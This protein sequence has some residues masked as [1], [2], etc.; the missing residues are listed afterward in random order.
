MK[1]SVKKKLTLH[2][3]TILDLAR[4]VG[5]K[6]EATMPISACVPTACLGT[7]CMPNTT[8]ERGCMPSVEVPCDPISTYC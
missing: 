5:G 6:D 3:E 1:R 2:R 7:A 4:V 8:P